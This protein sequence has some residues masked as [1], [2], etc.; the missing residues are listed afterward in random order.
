MSQIRI[1]IIEDNVDEASYLKKTFL[2]FD[3]DVVG[4][5]GNIDRAYELYVESRPHICVVDIYLNGKPDGVA[6]AQKISNFNE[7]VPIVFLTGNV[8][9]VTFYLAKTTNP[10]SYLLKPYNPLELQY[11]IELAVDK[12]QH[13]QI[14]ESDTLFIKRGNSMTKV[15]IYSIKYIEVDGKYSK[16]VC[17]GEKFLIQQSLKDLQL[18]LPPQ[19]FTRIHRNYMVNVKEITR[20]DTISHEVHFVDGTSL[21]FSRRYLDKLLQ[22]FKVLK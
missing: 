2:G 10:H 11:A 6:F 5:A 21:F 1:L 8:D 4:T 3:Y 7:T 13:D 17:A 18:Q 15:N 14:Q 9:N 22:T 12:K 16:I 20:I 19:L